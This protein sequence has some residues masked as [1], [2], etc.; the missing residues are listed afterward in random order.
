MTTPARRLP[1]ICLAAIALVLTGLSLAPAGA[2]KSHWNTNPSSTG[3]AKNSYTVA[4]KGVSGGTM[5]IRASRTCGTNWV[6]YSGK[7]QTTKKRI[8]DHTTNKWTRTDTDNAA[9]SFSM[10]VYAPGTTKITA[11][12]QIGSTTTTA[13]CGNGC[14]FSTSKPPAK[15]PAAKKDP[16][17]RLPFPKG[18]AYKITQSGPQ[19]ESWL[20]ANGYASWVPYNR[21]AVDFA[22]PRDATVSASRGGTVRR[23]NTA[24]NT[25]VVEHAKNSCIAYSHL[26]K[27]SVKVGQKVSRGQKL[28]GAGSKGVGTGV[29]LH[30]VQW[31]CA[32]TVSTGYINTLEVGT[33][34]TAKVGK[35]VTSKNG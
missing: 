35:F 30:W 14:K 27:V 4:S 18:K 9:S 29:H 7:K 25:V 22:M 1:V 24:D 19:H 10:Q 16:G 31:N 17:F 13:V 20:R 33:G 3:C 11:T 2:A 12:M 21:H 23:I 32:T 26:N 5:S 15:K 6:L 34:Y 8:K 28:G